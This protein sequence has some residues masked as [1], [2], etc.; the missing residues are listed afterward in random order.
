[1]VYSKANFTANAASEG[2]DGKYAGADQPT[3]V[4]VYMIDILCDNGVV[5]TYKGDVT[6]IR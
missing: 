2:W 6:L 1:M 5:L 3:G 4:Y